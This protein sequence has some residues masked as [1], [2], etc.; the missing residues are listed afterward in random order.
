MGPGILRQM[1]KHNRGYLGKSNVDI[2]PNELIRKD[3]EQRWYLPHHTI[4][5][6]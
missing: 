4:V 1:F 5:M 2:V 3:Y 6:H